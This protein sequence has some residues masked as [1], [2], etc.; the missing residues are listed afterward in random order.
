[1]KFGYTIAYVDDVAAT[2]GFYERAF[3][4]TRGMLTEDNTYGEL[5]TG[6]TRLAFAAR[7]FVATIIPIEVAPAGLQNA[8]PPVELGFV[9][10]D[11]EAA[12][13][14]A[15]DAGASAVSPPRA[16]PWGQIVSYVRD[17]NGFLVEICSP[18]S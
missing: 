13:T 1:M 17:I 11:V 3:G 10:D 9:T 2:L 14:Q 12:Y 18:I 7:A 4:L 8:A 15:V 5:E 6:G 16:K